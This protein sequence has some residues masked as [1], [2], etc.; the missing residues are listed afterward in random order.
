MMPLRFRV[1]QRIG[2]V[3]TYVITEEKIARYSRYA[4]E[5]R[6]TKNI[7]TDIEKAK[8]AGLPSPVAHG[9]H[10]LAF[11][12]EAM[13]QVFGA[14]WVRTGRLDVNLTALVFPGDRLAVHA[15]VVDVAP[16]DGGERVDVKLAVVNQSGETVQAGRASAIVTNR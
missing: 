9:R 3:R 13:M 10:V 2:E 4:L 8:L 11:V 14:A 15:T 5:G 6:E 16:V 7:H 12:S 1:G